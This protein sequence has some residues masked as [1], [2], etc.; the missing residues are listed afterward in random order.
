MEN[1]IINTALCSFGMSGVVF[2]APFLHLHPGFKFYG[3]WERTKN[4]AEEKYRGTKTFRSLNE[5][6]KDEAI[7]LVIVNT[8]SYTHYEY[9]KAALLAN[10]HVIV[11]KPFTATVI[12]A[13]ELIALASKQNKKI[14][15]F[16]SRRYDSD[17]KTVKKIVADGS[18]GKIIDAEIHYDRYNV[19]LSYKTH[20]EIP[21]PAVGCIYDLGSHI[22]DQ[23]LQLFGMPQ[24][25]FAEIAINRPHSLV[26]DYIDVKLFYPS[27][28]VSLKSSYYVREALPGFILHGTKGSFL[29]TRADVQETMLQAG[30]IPMGDSWGIEPASEKGLLHTER[31]GKIIR[32]YV[33]TLPGNY[34]E[35]FEEVYQA[36]TENKKMPVSAEDAANVI[37]VIE[38]AIK[39]N[40]EKRV[41]EL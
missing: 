21:G 30:Q 13:E 3:A 23:A 38:G 9:A 35:F 28:R 8:P 27:H 11:E 2:H 16:Q 6:L 17:F 34:G 5:M 15:V 12:E 39:S 40:K 33:D 18:I 25:L 1:R 4:L 19:D 26:D 22:I 29:K 20:K 41:I 37:K 24:S 14:T 7:E 31:D 10:K 32:D 36:I